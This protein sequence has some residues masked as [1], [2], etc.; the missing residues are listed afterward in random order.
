LSRRLQTA[1]SRLIQDTPL[2]PVEYRA[3]IVD[4]IG[5]YAYTRPDG[6]SV[7]PITALGP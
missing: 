3:K 5:N 7:T 1:D 6:V 2:S 4:A